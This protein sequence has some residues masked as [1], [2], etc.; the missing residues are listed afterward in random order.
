VNRNTLGSIEGFFAAFVANIPTLVTLRRRNS[1]GTSMTTPES[2]GIASNGTRNL[3][4]ARDE[5]R[6]LPSEDEGILR[7]RDIELVSHKKTEN[8][9][10]Y[11]HNIR[12]GLNPD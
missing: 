5:F 4:Y 6:Q 11:L 9:D 2:H 8:D 3:K 12:L 1:A 10:T 7:T